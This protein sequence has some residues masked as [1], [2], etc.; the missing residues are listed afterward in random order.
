MQPIATT[1]GTPL[2][3]AEVKVFC[4]TA[5]PQTAQFRK[6]AQ[7]SKGFKLDAP[8]AHCDIDLFSANKTQDVLL[9]ASPSVCV[10]VAK[11]TRENDGVSENFKG[12]L[13][14]A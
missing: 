2:E 9:D 7:E 14:K 3:Q 13:G 11:T 8:I 6:L 4:V 10:C 1:V 12:S 5:A